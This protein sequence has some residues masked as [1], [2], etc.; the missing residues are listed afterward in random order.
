MTFDAVCEVIKSYQ[1]G[2][3]LEVRTKGLGGIHG[4]WRIKKDECFDFIAYDYRVK[5]FPQQKTKDK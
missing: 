3:I 4:K 1:N 2:E 5:K